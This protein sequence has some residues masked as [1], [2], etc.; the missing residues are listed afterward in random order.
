M[1]RRDRAGENDA[2]PLFN[3]PSRADGIT[4]QKSKSASLV[5]NVRLD[6]SQLARLVGWCT[7]D[8]SRV[9]TNGRKIDRWMPARRHGAPHDQ[10]T[11]PRRTPVRP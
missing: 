11:P 1:S 5:V 6:S 10:P 2:K 8:T 4:E 9:V 3:I 7:G